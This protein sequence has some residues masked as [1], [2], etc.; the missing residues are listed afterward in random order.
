MANSKRKCKFCKEYI[1]TETGVKL[2]VG[3][4]CNQSHVMSFIHEKQ[5]K[6][7]KKAVVDKGKAARKDLAARKLAIKPKSK[8]L[9]EL[10]RS[11]NQYIK[12]RDDGNECIAC[13]TLT[14]GS[15]GGYR[16]GC[17]WHAGHYHSV[18]SSSYLRF[19]L[20]NVHL[21]CYRCN[22]QLSGNIGEYTPRLIEKIGQEKFDWLLRHKYETKSYDVEWIKRAIKICRLKIKLKLKRRKI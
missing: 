18:G 14:V 4:F 8:W 13:K 15:V 7:R 12:L 6:Q 2:P 11:F 16:G 1:P 9:S 20:W 17:G 3:F 19:N 21:E 22:V 10:Q 5:A